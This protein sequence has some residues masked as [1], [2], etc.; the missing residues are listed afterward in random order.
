MKLIYLGTP[1]F[2]V[3]SLAALHASRHHVAAVVTA[4]DKARGRGRC[5][6]P[7]DIK[8]K[9]L[10]LGLPLLQPEKLRDPDF[11]AQVRELRPDILV[12]VAFR[13]LPKELYEI[14]RFGAVNAHASLLPKYRGAAPINW[15]IYH[16]EH[17]TGITVFQI[18]KQVDTGQILYQHRVPI[19]PQADAGTME[20]ILQNVAA[21]SLL[22]T[23]DALEKGGI[24]PLP[25]NPEA[26]SP[27]PKL[28]SDIGYL[29]FRKEGEQLCRTVRAFTPRPGAFFFL[30]TMRI[31]IF[32]A[33]FQAAAA[34]QPGK[35]ERLSGRSFA[36]HCADGYFLPELLCSPGRKPLPVTDWLNGMDLSGFSQANS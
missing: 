29:D 28:H 27:A 8:I 17:E 5:Q 36:I 30:N 33:S 18:E 1:A 14:P 23:L 6:T 2:A 32:K 34:T 35:I 9:A 15:A 12:V 26:A 16:G 31:K 3:P 20:C 21:Q 22:H 25:Q 7:C 13:I 4:P 19:P 24:K 11:L 10:E